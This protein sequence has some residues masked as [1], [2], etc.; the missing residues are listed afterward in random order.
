MNWYKTSY[1]FEERNLLNDKISYL[2]SL[3]K[4]LSTLSDLVF[5]TAKN[6]KEASQRIIR[7]KKITSYPTLRNM[8]IEADRAIYDDPWGFS[9][10][11]EEAVLMI[12]KKV[13]HL[14]NERDNF[15]NKEN[16]EKYR[17]GWD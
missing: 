4:N 9:A 6:T 17:K 8:L 13:A 10:I 12:N 14:K 11:C 3:S 16:K 1:N 7:N 15:M 5:Q 2:E